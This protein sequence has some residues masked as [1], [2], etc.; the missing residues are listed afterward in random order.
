V[1]QGDRS[2]ARASTTR[3]ALSLV[4]LAVQLLVFTLGAALAGQGHARA[5]G[6]AHALV[7]TTS[8]SS[9]G[10]VRATSADARLELAARGRADRGERAGTAPSLDLALPTTLHALAP[11]S[12]VGSLEWRSSSRDHRSP[13]SSVHGARGPPAT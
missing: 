2:V 1:E 6:S 9:D 12:L 7:V 13:P 10:S 4:L 8:A 11:A 5:G 3:R